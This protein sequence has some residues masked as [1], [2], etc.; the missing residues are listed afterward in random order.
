QTQAVTEE[1]TL[2]IEVNL[3]AAERYGIRPGDVRRAAATLLSGLPVGS[4]YEQQKIFDVVVWGTATT[5]RSVASVRDVL[6]DTAAGGHVRLRDAADVRP[7]PS[8]TVIRH[9]DVRRSLD[10]SADVAGRSLGAAARDVRSR[11]AA[12]PF[13]LEYHAEVLTGLDSRHG[14][15]RRVLA[16]ALAAPVGLFLLL[17]AAASRWRTAVLLFWTLPLPAAGGGPA[18]YGRG[19]RRACGPA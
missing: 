15:W 3:A 14:S 4:L 8:P 1:P 16:V 9:N 6:T 2:Q 10:V 17:Q 12:M 19:G 7:A 13:P 5:R 11:L 18:G